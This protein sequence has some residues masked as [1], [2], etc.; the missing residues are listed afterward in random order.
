M[1]KKDAVVH[2]RQKCSCWKVQNGVGGSAAS[3]HLSRS[4]PGNRVGIT[5]S[6][7]TDGRDLAAVSEG[8][9]GRERHCGVR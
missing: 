1:R 8:E 2:N 4:Q 9:V 7:E 5:Y 6:A 3:A